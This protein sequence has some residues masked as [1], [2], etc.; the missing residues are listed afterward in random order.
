MNDYSGVLI[1]GLLATLILLGGCS[2]MSVEEYAGRKPELKPEDYFDGHVKAWGIFENRNG[3]VTREFTG[4]FQGEWDG[5]SLTIDETL[6][7]KSGKTENRTWTFTKTG[8]ETYTL[9][10]ENIIG[11]ASGRAKGNALHL[12]YTIAVDVDGSTWNLTA[13]DWMY[14][15]DEKT[16][17]NRA[18]LSWWWFKAGEL[19]IVYRKVN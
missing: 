15:Q 6:N 18:T 1:S 2:T 14:R 9:T 16:V 13:D 3:K 11:E 12:D 5:E 8:D 17:I 19:T 4:D 7:Y 10:A